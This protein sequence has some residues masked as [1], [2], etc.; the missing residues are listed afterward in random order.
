ML[1]RITVADKTGDGVW[2]TAEVIALTTH[3]I[4]TEVMSGKPNRLV[5]MEP[6]DIG[7]MSSALGHQDFSCK[8]VL[9][10]DRWS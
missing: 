8:E 10:K 2:S 1:Q 9:F 7:L 5:L 4:N 3:G 6:T